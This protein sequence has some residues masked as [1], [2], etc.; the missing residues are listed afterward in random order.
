MTDFREGGLFAH[1]PIRGAALK[2]PILNRVKDFFN[3]HDYNFD[4]VSKNG[5]SRRS[6][7]FEIKVIT[8]S[9]L[10]MTS[11]TKFYHVAHFIL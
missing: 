1:L 11:P 3:K 2:K 6:Q 7:N 9:F 4:D 5:D 10:S 8:L